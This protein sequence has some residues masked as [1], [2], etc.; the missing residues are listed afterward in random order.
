MDQ[1]LLRH[2]VLL[3]FKE[4]SSK[5]DIKK[6]EE[7]FSAL[8]DKI[9]E[10]EDYEWGMNNSSIGLDKGFTHCFFVSF[11]SEEDLSV[12]LPHPDHQAVSEVLEPYAEDM[13]IL[14]YWTKR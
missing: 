2:I 13:I 11:K 10:I 9:P 4:S 5:E 14:D 7:A 1:K 6:L 8:P 12:Y 3:K